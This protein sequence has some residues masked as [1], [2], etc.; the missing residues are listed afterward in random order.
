MAGIGFR[1]QKFLH[2]GTYFGVLKGFFFATFLVAGPWIVS[3]ITITILSIFSGLGAGEYD[4]FKTAVIY[5]YAFSLIFTGI[6]QMPLTRYLADMLYQKRIEELV[7]AFLGMCIAVTIPQALLA[8]AFVPVLPLSFFFRMTFIGGYVIVSLL[9]LA[10][11]FLG[12]LRDYRSISWVYVVGSALSFICARWFERSMGLD[13][14]FFG[15]IL[16]Q[17]FIFAGLS[18]RVIR[19]LGH[20]NLL[21]SFTCLKSLREFPHHLL[22]GL[23]YNVAIWIDKILFWYSDIRHT[24]CRGLYSFGDY[25][26][27]IFVAYATIIPA[28]GLFLLNVEVTFYNVYRDYYAAILKKQPLATIEHRLAAIFANLKF[29]FFEIIKVQGA[30]TIFL[31]YFT[32][33][34]LAKFH[35]P[36][37][38]APIVRWGLWGAFFQVLFLSTYL[39]LLYFDKFRDAL[40]VNLAFLLLNTGISWYCLHARLSS[41]Y[42]MGYFVS[43]LAAFLWAAWLLYKRLNNLTAATFMGQPLPEELPAAPPY[44]GSD[45][46]LGEV[47][48]PAPPPDPDQAPAT[49]PRKD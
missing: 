44:L 16:G 6:Y 25:D 48:Y 4:I 47:V 3:V 35:Y 34:L 14:A 18:I 10:M 37:H 13:G 46:Y 40:F 38:L 41:L 28:L 49:S 42:G 45:G 21:P 19:E 11:I 43:T 20:P 5:I 24:A 2:E 36:Q 33:E 17:A 31:F 30:I 8:I 9:W 27:G 32:P 29:N 39:I 15:F 26:T 22:I 12:C 23:S 1:M 7:P